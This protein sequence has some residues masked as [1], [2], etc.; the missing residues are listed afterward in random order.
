MNKMKNVTEIKLAWSNN[1]WNAVHNSVPLLL[2][3]GRRVLPHG[4]MALQDSSNDHT[5]IHSVRLGHCQVFPARSQDSENGSN[6]GN[7][8]D[9]FGNDSWISVLHS[10]VHDHQAFSNWNGA[11]SISDHS[12]RSIISVGVH[13]CPFRRILLQVMASRKAG[14]I[15]D[16][17]G[18]ED[19]DISNNLR[20]I[21]LGCEWREL[22]STHNLRSSRI[23]LLLCER[24]RI[25]RTGSDFPSIF[26]SFTNNSNNECS[27]TLRMESLRA[28][29]PGR[30]R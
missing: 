4:R 30:M 24:Q 21:P 12:K 20:R 9:C 28:G 23:I 29:I 25:S 5:H 13:V 1:L 11:A 27:S 16:G 22:R 2:V 3:S 6:K 14:R 8:Q 15:R 17:E 10:L 7:T 19:S 26:W 18:F